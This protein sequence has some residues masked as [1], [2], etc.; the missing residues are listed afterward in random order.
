LLGLVFFNTEDG[1]DIFLRNFG[2]L[3]TVYTTLYPGRQ[4]GS[5]VELAPIQ[6]LA[7]VFSPYIS[8]NIKDKILPSP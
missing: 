2:C 3:S 8:L 5:D 7:T 6:H 1:G 4:D